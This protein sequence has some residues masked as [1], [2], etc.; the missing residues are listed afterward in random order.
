L[1]RLRKVDVSLDRQIIIGM[2]VSDRFLKAVAAIYRPDLLTA[3]FAVTV[4][5]WCLEHLKQYDKAPGSHIEDL[6]HSHQRAGMDD[7]QADLIESFLAGLSEEYERANKFNVDYLLDQTE[8]LFRQRAIKNLAEDIE[9]HL[10]HGELEEA[11]GMLTEFRRLERP[12]PNGIDPLKDMGAYQKAFESR[13]EPLFQLPGAYGDM[14]NPHFIRG[15]FVGFLGKAKAGKTWRLIDIAMW[16]TKARCNVAVF[17][18][19]D[20]SQDDYMVRQGVYLSGKSNDP[21]YCGE[22]LVPVLDCANNQAATCREGNGRAEP[23]EA[24]ELY[25]MEHQDWLY[26]HTP[27]SACIKRNRMAFKGA[28]WWSVRPP[29]QPL[30]WREAWKN[31]EKWA[32]RHRAKGLRLAVYP[33]SSINVR[34]IEQQLDLWEQTEGFVPD[35]LILD[36]PDIMEPDDKRKEKRHQEDERWRLLRRVSQERHLCLITATQSNRGGFD[37][38]DLSASDTSEDKRKLDHVTAFFAINQTEEEHERG[39]VRIA[40]LLMREG[41]KS[42]SQ[43]VVLQSLETGQPYLASYWW[44]PAKK[45]KE[46]GGEKE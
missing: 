15:G 37:D 33:N 18:L 25:D 40:N 29:V 1:A 9:A 27:C 26:E 13:E 35:V 41:K 38:R 16:A 17:Q 23:I 22:L 46:K 30:T 8:R 34:G 45:R 6:F 2:I 10:S 24:G 20:L 43:V 21:R 28:L 31:T 19:G 4:A 42:R 7:D 3:P 36:Y 11:E 39:V 14:L 32:K 44:R 5:N 12:V